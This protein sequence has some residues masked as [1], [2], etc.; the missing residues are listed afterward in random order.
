MSGPSTWVSNVRGR[1]MGGMVEA[2]VT[3]AVQATPPASS[4]GVQDVIPSGLAASQPG[5]PPG[6]D[7]W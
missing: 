2:G 1:A 5:V 3:A 4:G 6:D 7:A